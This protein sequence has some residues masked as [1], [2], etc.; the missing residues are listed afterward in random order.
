MA[1]NTK[2]FF[3]DMLKGLATLA[4]AW[5]ILSFFSFVVFSRAEEHTAPILIS[6]LLV[7]VFLAVYLTITNHLNYISWLS[8]LF[9]VLL[10]VFLF[11]I[12]INDDIPEEAREF[13]ENISERYE[14]RYDYAEA[15]LFELNDLWISPVRQYLLE[16]HKNFFIKDFEYFWEEQGS[17]V[18]SNIQ[19]QIYRNLLLESNR[20]EEDEVDLRRTVCTNSP[21]TYVAIIHE[22]R[23]IY[24]DLWAS[25]YFEEYEFGMYTS[26][27]CN[28][29]LGER[30]E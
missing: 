20:F 2:N 7:F 11:Y 5:L 28:E 13:N 27:P 12:P 25:S 17:Y 16:P 22:D 19:S 24:A 29:L 23:E 9:F 26:I 14:D 4:S 21:H 1:N 6:S 15:L 30:F 3:L 18:D 8:T 10:L